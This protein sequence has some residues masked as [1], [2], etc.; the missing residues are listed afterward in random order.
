MTQPTNHEQFF[1]LAIQSRTA[2]NIA[3]EFND[4]LSDEDKA[5]LNK[6]QVDS[7]EQQQAMLD[8]HGHIMTQLQLQERDLQ[9][10]YLRANPRNDK[11]GGKG[12]EGG[13]PN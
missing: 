5:T 8:G 7:H 12:G 3:E 2:K 4:K 6:I 9:A 13:K 1:M 11:K 10:C